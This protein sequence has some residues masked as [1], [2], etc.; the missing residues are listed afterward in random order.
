MN[1]KGKKQAQSKRRLP[2]QNFLESLKDAGTAM[3]KDF[4]QQLLGVK[5]PAPDRK[6]EIRPGENL[7][8]SDVLSGKREGQEKL[9]K[10]LFFEKQLIE[11]EKSLLERKSQELR[12]QLHAI[13]QEVQEV[14]MTTAK[15]SQEVKAAT[16][17]AVVNPGIY[18]VRFFEKFLEYL[19]GY[20]R[21]I[22]NASHWLAMHNK[23]TNKR[24]FWNQYKVQKGTALLN[25]ETYNSRNAG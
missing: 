6:G 21:K 11:E 20:R 22:Q 13:M 23:R 16:M 3:P 1:D 19:K 25:P 17:Q 4:M 18:D 15:L 5:A 24:N 14:A 8:I 7:S 2:N 10:Q 12:L 9:Q